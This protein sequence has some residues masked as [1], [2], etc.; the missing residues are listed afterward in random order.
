[1]HDMK[2]TPHALSLLLAAALLTTP[3]PLTGQCPGGT[4]V[5]HPDRGPA[6]R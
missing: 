2:R 3:G 5:A 1:M 6:P 4:I